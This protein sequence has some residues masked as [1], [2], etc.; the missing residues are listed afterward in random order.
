MHKFISKTG[1]K[2]LSH[3]EKNVTW[4]SLFPSRIMDAASDA[5]L[6]CDST[7]IAI[8]TSARAKEG[9][10]F[11]PSPTCKE[12]ISLNF[13]SFYARVS[14]Y[15]QLQLLNMRVTIYHLLLP[16]RRHNL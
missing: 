14:Q 15:H 6:C 16:S 4:E 1:R 2:K 7:C 5:A 11:M 9:A 12:I 10:S 8:P 3:Q 13:S